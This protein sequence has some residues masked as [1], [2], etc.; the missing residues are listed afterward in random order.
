MKCM[1]GTNVASPADEDSVIGCSE[2]S[3]LTETWS[4]TGKHFSQPSLRG[5]ADYRSL[6]AGD[7]MLDIL[8]S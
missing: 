2:Q 4:S 3:R 8:R 7:A 6:S 1:I 5:A